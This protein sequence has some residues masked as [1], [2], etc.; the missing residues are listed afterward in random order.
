MPTIATPESA[1]RRGA[2]RRAAR[3][4]SYRRGTPTDE[5]DADGVLPR[6]VRALRGTKRKLAGAEDDQYRLAVL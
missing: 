6:V 5:S 1:L 3:A 4:A 2:R